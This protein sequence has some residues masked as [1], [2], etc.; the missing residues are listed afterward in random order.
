MKKLALLSLLSLF[1]TTSFISAETVRKGCEKDSFEKCCDLLKKKLEDIDRGTNKTL[2]KLDNLKE[3]LCWI[4]GLETFDL[5]VDWVTLCLLSSKID[6]LQT[7]INGM[8]TQLD[9]I[10]NGR[11]CVRAAECLL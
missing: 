4:V 11:Q 9:D 7:T 10:Y 5:E 6:I 8:S 2:C 3:I 1:V